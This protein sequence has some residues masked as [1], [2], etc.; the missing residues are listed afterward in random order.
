M[1]FVSEGNLF[2][3]LFQFLELSKSMMSDELP[4][5]VGYCAFF[6][7]FFFFFFFVVVVVLLGA[8]HRGKFAKF[9]HDLTQNHLSPMYKNFYSSHY[10]F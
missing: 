4:W 9:C 10:F 6:F 1:F 8:L 3:F 2:R 5:I 7:F